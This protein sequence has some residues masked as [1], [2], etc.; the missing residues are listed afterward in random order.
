[1]V[2]TG[3]VT[4]YWGRLSLEIHLCWPI[5]AL[6]NAPAPMPMPLFT[7]TA[8]DPSWSIAIQEYSRHSEGLRAAR[9]AKANTMWSPH[10][11]TITLEG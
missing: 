11:R 9:K 5:L 2:T 3:V 6:L 7:S 4:G 8:T 10:L 1:M